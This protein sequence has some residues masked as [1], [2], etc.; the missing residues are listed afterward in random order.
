M[1]W[2]TKV[3]KTHFERDESGQVVDVI[4]NGNN[5]EHIPDSKTLLRTY[6]EDK[7]RKRK[8]EKLTKLKE[9]RKIEKE[10]LKDQLE[11]QRIRSEI[12]ETKKKALKSKYAGVQKVMQGMSMRRSGTGIQSSGSILGFDKKDDK[13][14]FGSKDPFDYSMSGKGGGMDYSL[15]KADFDF[16]L[17]S[18]KKS[19]P[20][21][22]K[23]KKRKTKK[24]RRK[25]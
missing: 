22:K 17:T 23:T 7:K 1:K 21:K 8:E 24:K 18:S 6:K 4:H 11:I 19:K 9:K 10:K 3:E 14:N 13:W 15:G 2:G 25:K 20:K 12:R 5:N 16:S